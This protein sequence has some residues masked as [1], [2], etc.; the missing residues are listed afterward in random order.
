MSIYDE[1]SRRM[2]AQ[3]RVTW[4]QMGWGC[5]C[6]AGRDGA[7]QSPAIWRAAA[8]RHLRVQ[9]DRAVDA[10]RQAS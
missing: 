8:N 1:A 7:L 3:H 2:E 4:G 6:G 10:L 9:Y 5:S